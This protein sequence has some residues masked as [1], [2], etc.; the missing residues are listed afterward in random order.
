MESVLDIS[1]HKYGNY[2][3]YYTFHPSETRSSFFSQSQSKCTGD[4]D[5][6]NGIFY[7]IWEAQGRPSVFSVLDIGCNE[8][9][10]SMDVLREAQQQLPHEVK[11]I[12]LGVDI[13]SSL[14]DLANAKYSQNNDSLIMFKTVNFMDENE[15]NVFFKEYFAKQRDALG[16]DFSGFCLVSLFSITMWIHL[17]HGDEG[18]LSF[19]E[20]SA[21]LLHSS[22][23]LIVE[24]QPWKCYRNAD[25][26]CRKLGITRPLH[27]SALQIRDIEM[28]T[29]RIVMGSLACGSTISREGGSEVKAS[30][31]AVSKQTGAAQQSD[32]AINSKKEIKQMK[33][34][35]AQ[36]KKT[37]VSDMASP[38]PLRDISASMGMKSYWDLGKESW[39]RSILIFH[40][41]AQLATTVVARDNVALSPAD[42]AVC[43]LEGPG[44]TAQMVENESVCPE[45]KKTRIC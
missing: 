34:L 28:E 5:S 36:Q 22:G 1:A 29:V 12:L 43:N 14:I 13:D 16:I 45:N 39:G 38:F 18:F 6:S 30:E 25:K 33:K 23:S 24:P 2:H 26:R 42:S 40:K 17:N 31:G 4:S 41:S 9:N 7:Q 11:C 10:L 20:R 32:S 21:A 3:K 27:Y 44:Q 15:S 19:L 37:D 35:N 8:G